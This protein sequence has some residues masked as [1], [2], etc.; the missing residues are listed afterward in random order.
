M[1]IF[2]LSAAFLAELV[3]LFTEQHHK[4]CKCGSLFPISLDVWGSH[5][6]QHLFD[7]YSFAHF[8][9]GLIFASIFIR[10]FGA[11][12]FG[13]IL[14][15]SLIVEGGW[16]LLENSQMVIERYR[17]ATASQGYIG[18]S[19][20]NSIGDIISC[21]LGV[22]FRYAYRPFLSVAAFVMIELL[23][24]VWIRDNL[25]L[26]VIMLVSPVESIRSWQLDGAAHTTSDPEILKPKPQ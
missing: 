20:G 4:W 16:E 25:T 7:P 5:N 14:L 11:T 23:M 8:L 22:V 1:K 9:H 15:A 19:F 17:N 24:L 26:A 21:G 6:S 10:F 12:R 18:D 3:Y 13:T 2:F